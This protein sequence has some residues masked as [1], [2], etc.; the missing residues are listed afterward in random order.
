MEWYSAL[1]HEQAANEQHETYMRGFASALNT[2]L[3]DLQSKLNLAQDV[4]QSM[5]DG[6]QAAADRPNLCVW[7]IDF[8]DMMKVPQMMLVCCGVLFG[9][10]WCDVV[11]SGVVRSWR[12]GG[13]AGWLV[14]SVTNGVMIAGWWTVTVCK[15]WLFNTLW[16]CSWMEMLFVL[17]YDDVDDVF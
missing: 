15:Q 16:V 4:Y 12:A 1:I 7:A 9:V 10:M 13:L 6:T 17:H 8:L 11:W 2:P 14:G 3:H 5:V